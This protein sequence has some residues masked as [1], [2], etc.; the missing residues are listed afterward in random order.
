[1]NNLNILS[2]R[3][4]YIYFTL[5]LSMLFSIYLGKLIVTQKIFVIFFSI[6]LFMVAYSILKFKIKFII[7]FFIF[8]FPLIRFVPPTAFPLRGINIT[9]LFAV[10]VI[11]IV[12][13]SF[14]FKKDFKFPRVCHPEKLAIYLV[15]L[16][17]VVGLYHSFF[18]IY[19]G[20][21]LG[22]NS[23]IVIMKQLLIS[24]AFII[25]IRLSREPYIG[26]MLKKIMLFS[27][28]FIA[29]TVIIDR[30]FV[31]FFSSFLATYGKGAGL[32]Y[33]SAGLFG[34][35]V[36]QLGSFL[37]IGQA[38]FLDEVRKKPSLFN[39]FSL[40]LIFS[41][42]LFT[43]TRVAFGASVLIFV[44]FIWN[45]AKYKLI[46]LV[47]LL[48]ILLRVYLNFGD[49]IQYRISPEYQTSEEML[50]REGSRP[51]IWE[52]YINR[53]FDNPSIL[54]FGSAGG[55][56]GTEIST[57]ST[58]INLWMKGGIIFPI[59]FL[60]LCYKILIYT[61]KKHGATS[62][63]FLASMGWMITCVVN[64]NESLNIIA[65]L[66]LFL[67]MAEI[68]PPKKYIQGFSQHK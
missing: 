17:T 42:L 23:I 38:F 51:A 11:L 28:L 52:E 22:S 35:H 12:F 3:K 34:G 25:V 59:L 43:G 7:G 41:A 39:W 10:G 1:M 66:V 27:I 65:F 30:I 61:L 64:E 15:I 67:S 47:L 45:Y 33:R 31:N 54:L 50:Y 21:I 14:I 20:N 40:V 8:I 2:N 63:L 53:F 62:G 32:S 6:I 24:T 9:N 19:Y 26:I 56:V 36:T 37:V 46:S 16:L 5:I 55:S 18:S 29:V 57:H 4:I 49:T 58:I 13:F 44:I 60:F 68:P 48:M